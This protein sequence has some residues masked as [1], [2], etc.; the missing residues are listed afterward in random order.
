[1]LLC[2]CS[3]SLQVTVL[4][5]TSCTT[6][7]ILRTIL[8]AAQSYIILLMEPRAMF[9]AKRMLSGGYQYQLFIHC[10]LVVNRNNLKDVVSVSRVVLAI[11]NVA[12]Y[13]DITVIYFNN[14]SSFPPLIHFI[15]RYLDK[16]KTRLFS[17]QI[18]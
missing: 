13:C 10:F 14:L 5:T 8:T 18:Y 17:L 9:P 11:K 4:G 7:M 16:Q 3:Y 6:P 1:M 2:S 15:L 12:F